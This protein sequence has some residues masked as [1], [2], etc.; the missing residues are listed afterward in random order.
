M[1]DLAE[2]F[3]FIKDGF[4][5]RSS[6]EERLVEWRV[7]DRLH[8]LAYLGDEV[9][10]TGAHQVNQPSG[11]VPFVGIYEPARCTAVGF[12][13]SAP[14]VPASRNCTS[15]VAAVFPEPTCLPPSEGTVLVRP[16]AQL[17]VL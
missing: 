16:P 11:D 7:L 5:Q 1:L 13:P 14:G 10:V 15:A 17:S 8:V 12:V 4:N 2:I 6:L 9:H 3:Q